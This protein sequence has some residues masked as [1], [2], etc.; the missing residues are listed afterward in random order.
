MVKSLGSKQI[1]VIREM[2]ISN[3]LEIFKDWEVTYA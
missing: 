3:M 2:A 1:I